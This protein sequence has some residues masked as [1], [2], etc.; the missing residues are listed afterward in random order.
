M[1]FLS[2]SLRPS[3]NTCISAS[4]GFRDKVKKESHQNYSRDPLSNHL[5]PWRACT[6]VYPGVLGPLH[7]PLTLKFDFFNWYHLYYVITDVDLKSIFQTFLS[8]HARMHLAYMRPWHFSFPRYGHLKIPYGSKSNFPCKIYGLLDWRFHQRI[9]MGLYCWSYF[10]YC[11][12]FNTLL[13]LSTL[14]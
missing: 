9:L 10:L 4:R 2:F 5:T 1:P 14:A 3:E 6:L 8:V 7:R 13:I 12:T 11:C